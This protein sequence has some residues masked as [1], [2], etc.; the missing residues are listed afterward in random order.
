MNRIGQLPRVV[1]RYTLLQLPGLIL[2]VLVLILVQRWVVIPA[3]IFWGFII[4]WVVKDVVLFRYTWRAY[5]WDGGD[6]NLLIGARGIAKERLAP[7]G[8][9]QVGAE[10]WRAEV[11]GGN[12]PIESG[13]NVLVKGV[14]GFTLLVEAIREE[15]E[16]QL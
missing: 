3:W 13:M 16:L 8:Y 1:K 15:N 9:V 14:C 4:L 6:K 7:S 12:P 10:L 11:T 2:L 5:D